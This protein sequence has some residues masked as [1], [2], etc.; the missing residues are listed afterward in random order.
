MEAAEV[1]DDTWDDVG[2]VSGG[3]ETGV[4]SDKLQAK[5][6]GLRHRMT[7]AQIE[8]AKRILVAGLTIEGKNLTELARQIG[9]A[10]QAVSKWKRDGVVPATRAAQVARALGVSMRDIRPDV[11]CDHLMQ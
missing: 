11:F 8:H 2:V 4:K 1:N 10:P 5:Q 6:K 7:S 3:G 9:V